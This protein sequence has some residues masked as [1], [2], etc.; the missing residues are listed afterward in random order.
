MVTLRETCSPLGF[1]SRRDAKIRKDAEF[2]KTRQPVYRNA[3]RALPVVRLNG[4]AV[5]TPSDSQLLSK[6]P[7]HRRNRV[8]ELRNA[9]ER[10]IQHALVVRFCFS[11][12][13]TP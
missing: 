4:N 12:A 2:H 5:V 6:Q 1:V 3:G 9:F 10:L 8:M 7:P 13:L 11:R